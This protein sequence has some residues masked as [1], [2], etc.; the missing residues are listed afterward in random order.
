[1]SKDFKKLKRE[2]KRNGEVPTW[3]TTNSL[4]F[5][6]NKY[7][8]EGESVRSRDQ[9][10]ADY[11]ASEAPS[12][13]PDWWHTDPFTNG[14]SWE[15][16]FFDVVYTYGYGILS[17]PLKANGG[18]PERGMTVS[19][20]GQKLNNNIASKYLNNA[21]ISIFTKFAHGTSIDLSSWLSEGEVIDD[22]NVSEGVVPILELYRDTTTQV[23][24]GV[25]RGVIGLYLD[26][27]HGDTPKVLDMLHQ[28]PEA[29][30]VGFLYGDSFIQKLKDGDADAIKLNNR[31]ILTRM[32]RGKGYIA[33]KDTMNRNKARVFKDLGLEVHASNLCVAPETR[34]LTRDGYKVISELEGE[35]VE[36]WN[37]K[38]WSET[39]VV[40][41]GINQK[42]IKVSTSSGQSLD[43]TEYHKFYVQE[44]F[45]D[46]KVVEKRAAQLRVGDKLMK[47]DL[48]VVYGGVELEHAYT[49][50]F[51]SGDGYHS[52]GKSVIPLYHE[53]R[54]LLSKLTDVRY[55][56]DDCNRDRLIV[57]MHGNLKDK[58][59]VPVDGFSVESRLSW[60]AGILDSDGCVA[61]NGSN[62]SLQICSIHF[63]FLKEVQLML[64]TLGVQSKVT[65]MV[66][67]GYRDMPLNDGTGGCGSFFCQDAWRLLISSS[68]L[69]KLSQL[70][71]QTHRLSWVERLPQRNAEQFTTVLSVEDLGRF[72]D[73]YC[74]R[75]PKRH[76]GVFNG[77]L[78][79]QCMEVNL[80]ANDEYSFTCVILNANLAL[81]DEFPEHLFH[82]L[83]IMQDCNVSGYLKQIEAAK[84]HNRQLLQ[85]AYKFT[86]DFRAVGTGTAGFHSLLMQKRIVYGS[87]ESFYL[88]GQIFKRMQKDVMEA[89]RWLAKV[90]G[91]PEKLAHLGLRNATTMMMPPTKSS[92]ELARNTPSEGVG[93]ETALVKIKESAGGEIF[94]IN[95]EFLEFMKSKGMYTPEEVARIAKNKGSCQD[96][97]WMTEQEKAVFRTAFECPMDKHLHLCAQRQHYIDQQQS[98]NLYFSGSDTEEY[99]GEIHR[100]ALED[101]MINGLYYCYSVRGGKF[102]RYAEC[103]N[104]Q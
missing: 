58:F 33:K 88:N 26:I 40:K 56:Y 75:E 12:V 48:P 17:T 60:L 32:T 1:M 46:G 78:T 59:F 11:L 64:Q 36:V 65:K 53:K 54:K 15:Q 100:Q 47:W 27:E 71:L 28:D 34:I 97:T 66:D 81:Y 76:M 5:F 52:N 10:I 87:L 50:G 4:Q 51:Y 96:C 39:N 37:G 77:I 24:Q 90:L 19:C 89:N 25:R 3:Y 18:L 70:G 21:E 63:E 68:A 7:S 80:P 85:K 22:G 104:C 38:E 72:D 30:N 82:I 41:T 8:Y 67:S 84:P 31:V 13:K 99:I 83:H 91:S 74:F 29:L 98:I 20:S 102:V 6:M 61:R 95:F 49:N 94:R 55:T 42:L 73:I 44:G 69:F 57:H 101:D 14:K 93:L 43:C 16:V 103:E 62:E 2:W 35:S 86:Q 79:G 23:T 45:S 9:A 92:T